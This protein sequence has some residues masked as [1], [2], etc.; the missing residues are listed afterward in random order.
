MNAEQ[1]RAKFRVNVIST[2]ESAL[3]RSIRSSPVSL[4]SRLIV[5]ELKSI[6]CRLRTTVRRVRSNFRKIPINARFCQVSVRLRIAS[7][8]VSA[9]NYRNI[10]LFFFLNDFRGVFFCTGCRLSIAIKREKKWNEA[11]ITNLLFYVRTC[12]IS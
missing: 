9:K 5:F 12:H 3:P 6:S 1:V 2:L 8:Y 10:E 11:K 7:T 4:T